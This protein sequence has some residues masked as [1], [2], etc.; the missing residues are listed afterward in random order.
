MTETSARFAL[1]LLE[2]G[3]A[4]K[5][6]F[7]NEAVAAIDVLVHAA[8]QAIGST[9]PPTSPTIGQCWALG[10][11]PTGAWSGH[12]GALAAWTAGG[13]RFLAPVSGMLVWSIADG[14]HAQWSGTAWTVG[15]IAAS[16]VRIAGLKVLGARQAAIAAP[17]GGATTDAEARTAISAMLAALRSHGLIAP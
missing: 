3:Q 7:H 13:W 11:S 12:P 2:P 4:Q 10:A 16:E 6:L 1:P 14:V 9:T 5:E 8:A 17:S 15:S